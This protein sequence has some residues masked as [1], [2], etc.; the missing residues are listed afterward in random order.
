MVRK[1][2]HDFADHS[3]GGLSLQGQF[4]IRD[5]IPSVCLN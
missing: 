1:P 5:N 3:Y 2:Y 4:A